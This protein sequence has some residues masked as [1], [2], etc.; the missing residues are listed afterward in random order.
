LF[1]NNFPISG[2]GY[3]RL[4]PYQF[5]KWGLKS[6]NQKERRP[7]IFYIHPWE[8]DKNQPRIK[9]ASNLSKFRH[10]INLGRTEGKMRKL[11]NDF[12]FFPVKEV[13]GIQQQHNDLKTKL[14]H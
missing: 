5:T 14:W 11:L 8:F 2:G 1:A 3:F 13:L 12:K 10:Y 9:G 6:I 7:F 4:F